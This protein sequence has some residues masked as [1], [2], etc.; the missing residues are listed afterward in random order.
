MSRVGRG[1]R[2]GQWLERAFGRKMRAEKGGG[3]SMRIL[4][5]PER[6]GGYGGVMGDG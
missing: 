4:G 1:G 6:V 2:D 5:R 3:G